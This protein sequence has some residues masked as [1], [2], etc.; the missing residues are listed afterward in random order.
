MRQVTHEHLAEVINE[1][2]QR[3]E[4]KIDR[5]IETIDKL[6]ENV[7][8]MAVEGAKNT[9]L[10]KTVNDSLNEVKLEQKDQ[11]ANIQALSNKI[12][13]NAVKITLIIFIGGLIG[14][15]ITKISF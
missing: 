12:A 6:A 3:F 1:Q 9:S 2:E 8:K 4:K 5:L 13:V 7:N 15:L 14:G 10:A 11:R